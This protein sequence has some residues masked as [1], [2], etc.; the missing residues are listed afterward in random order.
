MLS[1]KLGGWKYY[2]VEKEMD[3]LGNSATR[4]YN[5]W[6]KSTGLAGNLNETIPQKTME[7][8]ITAVNYVIAL[9]VAFL[10]E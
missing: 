3:A 8:T 10:Q 9:L 5:I 2:K 6:G 4:S 1:V 7:W